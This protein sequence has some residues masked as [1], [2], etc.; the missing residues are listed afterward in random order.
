[1]ITSIVLTVIA[2]D[3][4][5]I[6]KTVSQVLYRHGGTWTE[7]SMASL[8]GKFAGIL[9]ASVDSEQAGACVQELKAL[10]AQ[11]LHVIVHAGE[12]PAVAG[13]TREYVLDLV[14]NDRKG[15]VHDIT[16]VLS[17]FD[18]NVKHLDTL[19]ESVPMGGGEMFKAKAKL[20]VPDSVDI[21]TLEEE[22]ESIANELMVVITLKK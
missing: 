19:V 8:A 10:E 16:S 13:E 18:V 11:G 3:H 17:R 9:L 1:M 21:D 2:D 22:L 14:G 12:A 15:I 20:V 5:G 6:V 4:P 7:S